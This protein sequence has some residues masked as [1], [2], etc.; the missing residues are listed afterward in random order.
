MAREEWTD[1]WVNLKELSS[2]LKGKFVFYAS[3]IDTTNNK[4]H[5]TIVFQ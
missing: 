4:I 2:S 1:E 5:S 3:C